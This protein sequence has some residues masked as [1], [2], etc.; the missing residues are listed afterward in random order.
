VR[1]RLLAIAVRVWKQI[2]V[3]ARLVGQYVRRMALSFG[4]WSGRFSRRVRTL[5]V[6]GGLFV[7]LFLLAL[8]LPVPYVVLSPGPTFNTLAADDNGSQ[9]IVI[10]GRATNHTT[11]NL[12]MTTVD[13][14]TRTLT[15][16]QALDGWLLKDE[17][18]VPRSSEFPPGQSQ[19]Q[20]DRQNKQ[21][22]AES[23][24][25]ATAAAQCELGYPPRF[26]VITVSGNSPAQ[27]KL[28][29]GDVLTSLDGNAISSD[30]EL[31]GMLAKLAPG[32]QVSVGVLRTAKPATVSVKLGSAS[33]RTGGVI[34]ISVGPVCAAPFSVDLGLG[35]QIGGP[36]AGMMFALGIIDKVGPA[37]LTAGRF[38]AGTG[39]ITADGK[40]GAIGGIALK[41]IAARGA[42]ASVFL[43]PADNCSDVR[44]AT[45]TGLNVVK[46]ATLHEAVQDLLAIQKGQSVPH[47]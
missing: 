30:T 10:K 14:S 37:D 29:P 2:E 27:G 28:E 24:D 5:I 3:G 16:F 1:Q 22:F 19:Q 38:I 44:G 13:V 23:Q 42:G 6:A 15:A 7:V 20:V 35:N 40:V 25:N 33:G 34:G 4:R 46:V 47:C 26:G 41:M 11:G 39:T 9:I 45:P 36:S 43:A 21:D 17:V 31:R 8:V 12:N 32:T 18:V